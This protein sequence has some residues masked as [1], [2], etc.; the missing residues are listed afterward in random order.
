MA[1]AKLSAAGEDAGG[2]L[3]KTTQNKKR[4]YPAGTHNS[5]GPQIRWIL[6]TGNPGSIRSRITTP[7][8]EKTQNLGIKFFFAH[9]FNS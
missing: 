9:L 7:V 3:S 6:V 8:T 5:D 4:I 1:F 2:T